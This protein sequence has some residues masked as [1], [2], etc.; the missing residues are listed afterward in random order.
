MRGQIL[1]LFAV[2]IVALVALLGVV[3]D[4]GNVYVQRRAAQGAA[5]AAALAGVRTLRSNPGGSV[6]NV[7]S[8]INTYA[9]ANGFGISPIVACA[10]FVGT[11]GTNL[12]GGGIISD[13]SVPGCPPLA[14]SIPAAASG[15]HV[16]IRIPFATYLV[17]MFN[18]SS[19]TAQGHATAQVGVVTAG[20]TRYAPLIVCG[21]GGGTGFDAVKL[22]TQTPVVVTTTPGVLG[23][24]PA[25]L[26]AVI[27]PQLTTDQILVTP[28]A[29]APPAYVVNPASD[30]TIYYIKGQNI[31]T[32]NGSNCGASGFHGAASA[33][34]TVPFIQDAAGATQASIS[35]QTGNA[36]PQIAYQVATSGACVAGTN[37]AT[38]WSQGQPGCVMILPLVT[39][40][41]GLNFYVQAWAAFYVWC[42]RSTG[43]G[44]QEFSGQLLDNWPLAGGA[45]VN[46]WTVSNRT[47]L[48]VLHLTQ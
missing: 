40:S 24:T 15:V 12:S 27:N 28:V 9:A 21:G 8:A 34:Q 13:G 6:S 7:A 2:A 45:A 1:A 42:S 23:P 48:T 14:T 18:I 19:V 20:D 10:A 35:G 29:G 32:S 37:P 41:S 31:S 47:G 4:G 44:C 26:P 5:D 36:V 43:S 25:A 3:V 33:T 16:D 30:G 22:T 46:T 17:G 39:G 38:L 11:N